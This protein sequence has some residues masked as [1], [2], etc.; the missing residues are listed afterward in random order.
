M[1]RI[2]PR[3]RNLW[4]SPTDSCH[5]FP[6]KFFRGV[7]MKPQ[8]VLIVFSILAFSFAGRAQETGPIKPPSESPIPSVKEPRFMDAPSLLSLLPQTLPTD[9]LV[10]DLL[11]DVHPNHC[12]MPAPTSTSI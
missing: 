3:S 8:G 4:T 5:P 1:N 9:Y 7:I 2:A 10:N 6:L 12:T 11:A